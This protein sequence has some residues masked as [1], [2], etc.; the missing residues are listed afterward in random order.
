[1]LGLVEP[2]P[3][4]S[5]SGKT[6]PGGS[7][8]FP[9]IS[10]VTIFHQCIIPS[11]SVGQRV[12]G[13][14]HNICRLKTLILFTSFPTHGSRLEKGSG[15]CSLQIAKHPRDQNMR[16]PQLFYFIFK[17]ISTKPL[18]LQLPL[19]TVRTAFVLTHGERM[20]EVCARDTIQTHVMLF[21]GSFVDLRDQLRLSFSF[22][23]FR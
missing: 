12:Q 9:S 2:S 6:L 1:M 22:L 10:T 21:Q 20:Y 5:I 19:P 8:L 23:G 11:V 7:L 14:P 17:V 16:K 13:S 18:R 15:Y 3:S 4:F